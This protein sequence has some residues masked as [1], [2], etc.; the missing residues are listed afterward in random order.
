MM[1]D[2]ETVYDRRRPW[3][4]NEERLTS[5]S[6]AYASIPADEIRRIRPVV[7]QTVERPRF[8]YAPYSDRQTK[9]T[10]IP[11]LDQIYAQND[12]SGRVS[13]YSGTSFPSLGTF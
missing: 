5:V 9:I 4:S 11:M 2:A 6:L 3:E 7:P 13:G 1:H 8:G 12:F 10:D